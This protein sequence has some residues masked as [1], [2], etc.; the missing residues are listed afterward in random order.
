MSTINVTCDLSVPASQ[1]EAF[2]QALIREQ[3]VEIPHSLLTQLDLPPDAL[4]TIQSLEAIDEHR[5]R[6]IVAYPTHLAA[7]QLPQLLNLLYGNI[8]IQNGI[9]IVDL[10]LPADFTT[11]FVGPRYGLAGL[12]QQLGI[13]AR[14]LL[15]T[16]IKPRGASLDHLVSIASEFALGGGDLVKDDHNLVDGSIEQFRERIERTQA[17]V[18]DANARTGGNTLYYPT[19]MPT[20]GEIQQQVDFLIATGVTG[21]LVCPFVLGLDVMRHLRDSTPLALLAHPALAGTF[22]HDPNHGI[23]PQVLLGKLTRLA[24]AGWLGLPELRRPIRFLG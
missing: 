5:Q 20:I 3:S 1:A 22:F 18:S 23:E 4:G 17:A 12:R 6:L 7:N 24:G 10:E 15:A 9:R 16:A 13:H 19:L 21:V 11:Q 14:P 8:S 2:A